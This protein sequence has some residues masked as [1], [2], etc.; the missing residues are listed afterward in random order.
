MKLTS[1]I[2]QQVEMV[3]YDLKCIITF[4]FRFNEMLQKRISKS[5]LRFPSGVLIQNK[6]FNVQLSG[7]YKRAYN[8]L[9]DLGNIASVY[10]V[11]NVM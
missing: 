1:S 4:L 10:P 3:Q 2:L 8:N 9:S 11:Q 5:N 6:K 7:Q